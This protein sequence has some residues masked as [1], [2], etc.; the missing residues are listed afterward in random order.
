[1]TRL[2]IFSILILSLFIFSCDS[3]DAFENAIITHNFLNDFEAL[4][5]DGL[6]N[7]VVEIPAGSNQKWEVDKES[8]HLRWEITQDTLRVIPYLPY[9][10]NY[11]M[12]PK[13]WLPPE[14]GGDDDPIDIFLLGPAHERGAVIPG[15]VIGVIKMLD[16]GEQDDKLIA[17]DPDSWFWNIY[18]LEE[19]K[20]KFPGVLEV[21]TTWIS[22][23]KGDGIIQLQ[24]VGDEQEAKNI[25]DQ[26]IHSFSQMTQN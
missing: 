14:D 8:G 15:R 25:L 23:Y 7:I 26:A 5:Q 2:P 1:M 20:S 3:N 19:L 16:E 18:T 4:N 21:L 24:Y 10:A 12:V 9:P 11:G 6:A 17:V 22:N 13:T